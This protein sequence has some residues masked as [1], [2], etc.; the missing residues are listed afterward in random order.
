MRWYPPR[1]PLQETA[2]C[3]QYAGDTWHPDMGC[4]VLSAQTLEGWA[5]FAVLSASLALARAQEARCQ[6]EAAQQAGGWPRALWGL[7]EACLGTSVPT[8]LRLV[9]LWLWPLAGW[10]PQS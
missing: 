10:G 7:L 6:Q 4:S 3:Q 5:A 1:E 2:P 9:F 8:Y